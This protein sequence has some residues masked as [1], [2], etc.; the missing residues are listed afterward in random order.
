MIRPTLSALFGV[1]LL[2][3]SA[4]SAAG[5]AAISEEEGRATGVDAYLYFYPLITM[6]ITRRVAIN[7]EAGKKRVS[8]HP[9]RLP[10][11]PRFRLPILRA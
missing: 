9:T 7:V 4:A 3:R 10:T 11:S 2:A 8:A 5:Q 6:D 1:G